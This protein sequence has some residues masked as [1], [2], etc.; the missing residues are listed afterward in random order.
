MEHPRA[1][2]SEH[3]EVVALPDG[4]ALDLAR[5]VV[6]DVV[7]EDVDDVVEGDRAGAAAEGAVLGGGGGGREGQGEGEEAHSDTGML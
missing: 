7:E 2:L 3:G 6:D 4:L 5:V 1:L